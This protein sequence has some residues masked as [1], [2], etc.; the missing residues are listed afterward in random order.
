MISYEEYYPY[1]RSAYRAAASGVDLSLKRYRFTGK[2]RDEETGLDYF[3]V[4]Y[5][6]P[7]LGRWTSGDPGGFVDGLNLYRYVRNNPVNGIDREGYSTEEVEKPKPPPVEKEKPKQEGLAMDNSLEVAQELNIDKVENDFEDWI[8]PYR[9]TLKTDY[10]KQFREISLELL[11]E[12]IIYGRALGRLLMHKDLVVITDQFEHPE[13]LGS[14][15]KGDGTFDNPHLVKFYRY[16]GKGN[17]RKVL[18]KYV[19]HEE[20]IHAAQHL[21]Y[22][23]YGMNDRMNSILYLEA[24]VRVAHALAGTISKEDWIS[25]G[26]AELASNWIEAVNNGEEITPELQKEFD[27]AW[28]A[29]VVNMRAAYSSVISDQLSKAP[30]DEIYKDLERINNKFNVRKWRP[31]YIEGVIKRANGYK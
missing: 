13:Y 16:D 23:K 27:K 3:G 11:D 9:E 17:E 12:S 5:Y 6:A 26:F 30:N 31:L 22:K 18:E 24:E 4:R 8:Y 28:S 14:F 19:V 2:E 29:T 15:E 7:W 25:K 1:G 20:V 10:S 21:Y